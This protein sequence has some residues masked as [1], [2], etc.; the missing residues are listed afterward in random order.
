MEVYSSKVMIMKAEVKMLAP[1]PLQP[2]CAKGCGRTLER[3][4]DIPHE[5]QCVEQNEI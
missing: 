4:E 3:D 1:Q 5:Q 2:P